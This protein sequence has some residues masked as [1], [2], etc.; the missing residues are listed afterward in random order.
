M[1][2]TK[3]EILDKLI[4]TSPMSIELV[5][6]EEK[7]LI[8]D[9]GLTARSLGYDEEEFRSLSKDFFKSIVH[10]EDRPIVI[11]TNE[12][13]FLNDLDLEY[14]DIAVRVLKKD[15]TYGHVEVRTTVLERSEDGRPLVY[16]NMVIDITHVV[17]LKSTI[18][19]QVEKLEKISWKNSHELRSPVASILG[20]ID[21]LRFE[22]SDSPHLAQI[23]GFLKDTT[24]KLDEVIHQINNESYEGLNK[25]KS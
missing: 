23:L 11:E 25:D 8:Y 3:A 22:C 20:L 10:P 6:A 16:L 13:S 9:N 21:T 1:S 19:N 7:R 4:K 17:E 14:K 15:G 18:K 12:S 24:R 2:Y 5:S